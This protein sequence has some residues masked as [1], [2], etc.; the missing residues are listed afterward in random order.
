MQV[1]LDGLILAGHGRD[2][3]VLCRNVATTIDVV[4]VVT[5]DPAAKAGE[6]LIAV[7]E[8]DG[9]GVARPIL[10]RTASG[11]GWQRAG[12]PAF[13]AEMARRGV[14]FD[15]ARLTALVA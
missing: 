14:P 8:F 9:S 2:R 5:A 13:M 3:S 1:C 11:R 4:L 10:S 7:G 6:S 12:K 15:A